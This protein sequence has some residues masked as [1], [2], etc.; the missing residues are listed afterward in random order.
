ME[1]TTE[2][3][4][5]KYGIISFAKAM[6]E[7]RKTYGLTEPEFV[8]HITEAAT[9]LYPN[10]RADVAFAKLY[11]GP[12]G[13]VLREACH[14]CKLEMPII[15]SLQP[16]QSGGVDEQTRAIEETESSEAYK[17][18]VELGKQKWPTAP[19]A[20]AFARAMTENPALAAKVHR[21]PAPTTNYPFPR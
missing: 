17:Q 11:T 21:R 10:M 5:K 15:V 4:I 7:D 12:D 9:K 20:V 1:L 13:Q 18:L 6:V 14:L 2:N 19:E 16:M 3:V 8:V